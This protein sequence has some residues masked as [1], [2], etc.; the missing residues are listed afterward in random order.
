MHLLNLPAEIL[1]K[2]VGLTIP[3]DFENVAVSCRILHAASTPF[4]ATHNQRRKRFRDFKYSVVT[5][6]D[7]NLPATDDEGRQESTGQ[8]SQ[9]L[10][11]I[12]GGWDDAVTVATGIAVET[13][14]D[15]LR[16]IAEEPAVARYIR[17]ADFSTDVS[18]RVAQMDRD[19]GHRR[20]AL[21]AGP[22]DAKLSELVRASTYLHEAG[23]DT[24]TWL[25]A[26]VKQS[27][28]MEK[29]LHLDVFL[30][31]LL[32]DIVTL[33]PTH[34]WKFYRSESASSDLQSVLD[35]IVRRANDVSLPDASLARLQVVYPFCRG[36]Y[37]TRIPLECNTPFLALDSLREFQAGSCI[38]LDD[39]YTGISFDPSYE[40]YGKNLE[41]IALESCIIG[42]N[43]LRMLLSRTPNLKLLYLNHEVKWHGCGCNWD[44]GASICTI[45]DQ[46]GA[47]LESLHIAAN[48]L[49]SYGTTLMDMTDFRK[50]KHLVM[51]LDMLKG[52]EYDRVNGEPDDDDPP[53][54]GGPIPRLVDLL[55]RSAELVH[56]YSI[57][58]SVKHFEFSKL[59][60]GLV[61]EHRSKLPNLRSLSFTI[62][63]KRSNELVNLMWEVKTACPIVSYPAELPPELC[64]VFDFAWPDM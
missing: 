35:V 40:R 17:S 24:E 36:G 31:T 39:G 53:I 10:N 56:I 26:M 3:N 30:L 15:L 2:V 54:E 43:E 47:T 16:H 57:G 41:K 11:L 58:G 1:Q 48:D 12:H 42:G 55:P 34:Q 6:I 52:L 62:P 61:Q 21:G 59:F 14:L 18:T 5:W 51:D 4:V 63:E 13:V 45:M 8:P 64:R 49:N 27:E 50:L 46:V 23:V 29:S 38:A 20:C 19:F 32:P 7:P 22:S 60:D 9:E 33:T 28:T 44:V 37:D 25:E